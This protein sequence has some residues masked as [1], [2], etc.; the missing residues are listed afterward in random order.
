MNE[1][2]MVQY[3]DRCNEYLN[4]EI[5]VVYYAINDVT[6]HAILKTTWR[7]LKLKIMIVYF[8]L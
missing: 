2:G 5:Y 3:Y 7:T 6:K 4:K 1:F 8:T